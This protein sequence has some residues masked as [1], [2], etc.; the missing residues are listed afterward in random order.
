LKPIAP[1]AIREGRSPPL[2]DV[3]TITDMSQTDGDQ[4]EILYSYAYSFFGWAYRFRREELARLFT[5][6][7]QAPGD[8]DSIPTGRIPAS[9]HRAEFEAIFGPVS[10]VEREWLRWERSQIRPAVK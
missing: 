7:A 4:A 5:R 6:Y 3:I 8:R 1:K 10:R 9:T 2:A